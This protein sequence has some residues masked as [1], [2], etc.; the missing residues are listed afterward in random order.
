M[1]R[2]SSLFWY[3]TL[4]LF[5]FTSDRVTKFLAVSQ[6]YSQYNVNQFLSFTLTFNR[7]VSWGIFDSQSSILFLLVSLLIFS[8]TI[9]L[10]VL[11]VKRYQQGDYIVGETLAIAG[12]LSN[13]IDRIWYG[14]VVDFISIKVATFSW[15]IFN[16]ADVAIV[17]GIV[18]L[19][20]SMWSKK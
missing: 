12:S 16:I 11:A 7:G 2:Y 20:F 13:I 14:G 18:I 17:V 3:V 19:C 8:I 6:Q 15:P 5:V 4:F 9:G 1:R 10:I